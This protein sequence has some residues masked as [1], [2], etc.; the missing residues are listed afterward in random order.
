MSNPTVRISPQAHST[1]KALAESSGDTMQQLL[2]R[3]IE[4]YRRQCFLEEANA[5]Y[6]A[7]RGDAISWAEWQAELEGW[8]ST[9][10]DGLGRE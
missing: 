4:A 2:D 9:L 3:A 7:L 1:L 10:L 6:E 8:D 5:S